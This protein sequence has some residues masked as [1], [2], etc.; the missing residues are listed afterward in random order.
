MKLLQMA[1]PVRYARMTTEELRSTFLLGGMFKPGQIELAYVDLDR[2][3]IGGA[4][5]TGGAL[6]LETQPELR[7]EYFLERRE[8]GVFNVGGAGTVTV[9]G[10]AYELD[11][12]DTLYVGR[13]SKQVT[14]ASKSGDKPAAFYLLSY[15]AHAQFPTKLVK[16]AEIQ[17]VELGSL[18]T[19]N[20]RKIYK[21]IHLQ[22]AR[23]S[24]L[25][26]GF[27][28]LETGSNWNTMPAHTHMRRSEVYFYFDVEPEQRVIHLMGP[29]D[30]TSHI[31]MADKQ[32]V[33]SPGWSIHAGVG[34]K[35]YGFCWGMG[36]E[37]QDYADMDPV[38]IKDLQ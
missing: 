34:T 20:K 33:V 27:T 7:A 22:G 13:G 11:K 32:V 9:D 12:M 18:E 4:V 3:V 1:D 24:Q 19:C 29:P 26:M 16:F 17:P 35:A 30:A 38:A 10:T 25:V 8:I 2:T 15:Q 23:S 21:A 36:G 31:V 6:T 37:N 28:I 14:F 5:P